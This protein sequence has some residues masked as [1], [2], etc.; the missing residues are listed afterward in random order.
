M[1]LPKRDY[2]VTSQ[3][4][5]WKERGYDVK[6]SIKL[7]QDQDSELLEWPAV[8][9]DLNLIESLWND[10]SRDVFKMKEFFFSQAS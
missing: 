8:S 9:K 5:V 7:F 1:I 6:K 10:L 2:D 4:F 3:V